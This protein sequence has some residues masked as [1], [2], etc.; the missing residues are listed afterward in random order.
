[1]GRLSHLGMSRSGSGCEALDDFLFR[2]EAL[3]PLLASCDKGSLLLSACTY[4]HYLRTST[5]PPA[6]HPKPSHTH[7]HT[8][9]ATSQKSDGDPLEPTCQRTA[10]LPPLHSEVRTLSGLSFPTRHFRILLEYMYRFDSGP[11]P[12]AAGD[13]VYRCSCYVLR[14]EI[15]A[16]VITLPFYP[17]DVDISCWVA[18]ESGWCLNSLYPTIH[19]PMANRKD[20]FRRRR[21]TREHKKERMNETCMQ[22]RMRH[23]SIDWAGG[24]GGRK[25]MP[26]FTT[27]Q[28]QA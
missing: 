19:G 21:R 8:H 28:S 15:C 18:G 7:T 24:A 13:C 20:R 3:E 2:S 26:Y 22:I 25:E 6:P 14:L 17:M 9:N 4:K 23:R 16:S 12:N 5:H 11:Q 10:K 27:T 1:M